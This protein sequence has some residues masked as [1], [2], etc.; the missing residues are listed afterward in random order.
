MKKLLILCLTCFLLMG[1]SSS[2]TTKVE[3]ADAVIIQ[4]GNRK[5]TKQ[6]L[7]E[8]MVYN[9]GASATY[10]RSRELV[11]ADKVSFTD[12]NESD[13]LARFEELKE[14]FGSDFELYVM[15]YGYANEQDYYERAFVPSYKQQLLSKLYVEENLNSFIFDLQPIKVNFI[16][17]KSDEILANELLNEL[18]NGISFEELS[19]EYGHV[20]EID[21]KLNALLYK[22]MNNDVT[23]YTPIHNFV[24]TSDE[25]EGNSGLQYDIL[26]DGYFIVEV[27]SRDVETFQDEFTDLLSGSNTEI[28]TS[29]YKHYLAKGNFMIYDP[30]IHGLFLESY[31]DFLPK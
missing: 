30:V 14:S 8:T 16:Y 6:T 29:A 1:C 13:M 19:E 28:L 2:N 10:A 5:I 11:L 15:I 4:I 21:I 25:I 23:A 18:N 27:L 3:D 9:Y 17:L 26:T 20:A 7:Y 24:A 31:P 22:D 12:E